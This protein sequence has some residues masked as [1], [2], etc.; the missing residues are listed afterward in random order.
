MNVEMLRESGRIIFECVAGSRLYSLH[1]P[2]KSD[3]DLRGIYLNPPNEY[4]GLNE[5]SNQ[6]GDEKNDTTY[7]SLKRFFEL[8][9]TANPNILELMW[10]PEECRR[11]CGFIMHKIIDN[12]NL[13]ISKKC[14]HTYSGYAFAQIKK[15]QGQNKMVNH[16]E[17]FEKPVKEDFCH[18][19]W[20]SLIRGAQD[21]DIQ[22]AIFPARP[23]RLS[24][25]RMV[26]LSRYHAAALEH[27]SDA[28]RLY[29]YGVNS[30]GVF[31]GDDMLV[32]ESIPISDEWNRFEG[33]LIYNKH[34]Y[35]RAMADHKKYREWLDTRNDNRWLDQENKL[36]Q[37]DAKNML[38]CMRLL[39]SGENILK[40]GEPL[41]RFD[42]EQRD[43]LMSIRAG[44]FKYEELMAEVDIRMA[45]LEELNKTSTIPHSVNIGKIEALYR[46]L[47]GV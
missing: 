41:V 33:I 29:D 24:E 39:W 35:E 10:V 25:M 6:I 2:D 44:K 38:H 26:N 20:A 1:I 22:K 37:Y 28:Y 27:M 12:R 32:C 15:A 7:Y 8:A 14:F 31:R 30:K 11:I 16:P 40:Y 18:I 23:K 19:I 5:P 45:R 21:Q 42:G 17:L 13:F 36:V 46:E 34:E 4:L 43:Y 9:M 47:S 3:T